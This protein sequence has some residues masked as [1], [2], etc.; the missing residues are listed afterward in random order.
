M[1]IEQQRRLHMHRCAAEFLMDGFFIFTFLGIVKIHISDQLSVNVGFFFVKRV[2][3]FLLLPLLLMARI[4]FLFSLSLGS[5]YK[6]RCAATIAAA[7]H[8]C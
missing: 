6:R 8:S 2:A 7:A 3:V 5:L 1:C 4:S